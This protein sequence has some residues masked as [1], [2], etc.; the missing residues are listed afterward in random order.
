M[1]RDRHHTTTRLLRSLRR[2]GSAPLSFLV[3]SLTA[4]GG[5][6]TAE[7]RTALQAVTSWAATAALIG[8]AWMAHAAPKEY[9]VQALCHAH[10]QLYKQLQTLRSHPLPAPAAER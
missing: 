5:S 9:A 1:C 4:C 3:F 2:W 8:D 7:A 10:R 6:S